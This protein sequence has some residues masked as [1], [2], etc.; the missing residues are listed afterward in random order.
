MYVFDAATNSNFQQQYS[1]NDKMK[2]A[3]SNG[4]ANPVMV[5]ATG[6][7]QGDGTIHV[8]RIRRGR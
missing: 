6:S 5:T 8:M 2:T 1:Q 3:L 4:D 7:V